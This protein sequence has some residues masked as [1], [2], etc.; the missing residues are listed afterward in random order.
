MSNCIHATMKEGTYYREIN[1]AD[2][3]AKYSV[4]LVQNK[5]GGGGGGVTVRLCSCKNGYLNPEQILKK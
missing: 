2:L 1:F 3:K 5:M 4:N